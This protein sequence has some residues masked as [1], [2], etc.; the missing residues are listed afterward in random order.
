MDKSELKSKVRA[1]FD[2]VAHELCLVSRREQDVSN[3]VF[4]IQYFSPD[5]GIEVS[6]DMADFFIYLLI[7]K[8]DVQGLP[9]SYYDDR[10]CRCKLYVQEALK[11]LGVDVR[12]VTRQLH[13][14]GGDVGNCDEMLQVLRGLLKS[15]WS[16]LIRHVDRWFD[17]K[18]PTATTGETVNGCA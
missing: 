8:P 7:G 9:A 14:L 6:V 5:V 12:T 3:T 17:K 15:N 1:V 10:G 18:G 16:L 11:M 4:E 2:A 13:L